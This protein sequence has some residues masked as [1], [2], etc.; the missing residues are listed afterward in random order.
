[1]LGIG[2]EKPAV[3]RLR[4]LAAQA[5]SYGAARIAVRSRAMTCPS[6]RSDNTLLLD[7]A[8]GRLAPEQSSMITQ[9]ASECDDC[10]AALLEYSA[11]SGALDLWE[12]PPVSP[13]FNPRLWERIE[14]AAS[15][16]W[17]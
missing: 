16:P 1:M 12:A 13:H 17:Y 4:N 9:H 5:W 8:L 14:S 11:V 6:R 2:S 10:A 3:P 15:T 7:Y